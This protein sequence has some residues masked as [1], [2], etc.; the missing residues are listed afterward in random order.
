MAWSDH[1]I[2][3][4]KNNP[5]DTRDI[6]GEVTPSDLDGIVHRFQQSADGVPVIKGHHYQDG[7]A[8]AWVQDLKVEQDSLFAKIHRIAP[9]FDKE[10]K[11]HRYK[12]RSV[13]LRVDK[14]EGGK[15]RMLILEH[16]AMLGALAPR[17]KSMK[18]LRD[19]DYSEQD[20]LSYSEAAGNGAVDCYGPIHIQTEAVDMTQPIQ[21][22]EVLQ[23]TLAPVAP[24]ANTSTPVDSSTPSLPLQPHAPLAASELASHTA[25]PQVATS[26]PTGQVEF[27][28]Q[29]P[30]QPPAFDYTLMADALAKAMLPVVDA[31]RAQGASSR[32]QEVKDLQAWA[33]KTE[34]DRRAANQ[35]AEV[36]RIA[37]DLTRDGY[38]PPELFESTVVLLSSTIND[39]RTVVV[40]IEGGRKVDLTL[41]DVY[42]NQLKSRGQLVPIG[43]IPD[44]LR[45]SSTGAPNASQARGQFTAYGN[46]AVLTWQAKGKNFSEARDC[47]I[48]GMLPQDFAA[49]PPGVELFI[50][51]N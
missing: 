28:Q 16:V 45:E 33:I 12:N 43:K 4:F 30:S 48:A 21:D 47:V 38:I 9:E 11:T 50:H 17:L 51:S 31:S 35:I 3:I 40:G 29:P 5:K 44:P 37:R 36:K 49:P 18:P 2:E 1:W 10:V 46:Q 41:T 13:R 22:Q 23:P 27:T 6:L 39:K 8:D 42:I 25:P 15:G 19:L 14:A 32:D 24:Q 20:T 34:Q 26:Q 7:A